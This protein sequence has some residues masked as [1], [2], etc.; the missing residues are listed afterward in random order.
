MILGK[1]K[2]P[3]DLMNPKHWTQNGVFILLYFISNLKGIWKQKNYQHALPYWL[4]F[5]W[6]QGATSFMEKKS[7]FER[8]E[9]IL[10]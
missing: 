4:P 7:F 10:T 8:K 6:D 5:I 9:V 2:K 1:Q 3:C